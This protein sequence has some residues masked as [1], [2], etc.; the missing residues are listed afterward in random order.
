MFRIKD[1]YMKNIYDLKGKKIGLSKEIY[2]NF[3]R[4]EVI[5]L[6]IGS[7]S[8]RNRNNYISTKD[9][10]NVDNNI[11]VRKS[12][13]KEGELKFSDIRDMDVIDKAGNPKGRCG[14]YT[15]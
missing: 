15:Y 8:I 5:G 3:Y 13:K 2:I 11:L 9:I 14:G 7:Y 4:G 6:G 10:I 1:L 12:I